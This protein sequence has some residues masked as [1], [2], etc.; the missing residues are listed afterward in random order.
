MR[1]QE[2][3]DDGTFV[4]SNKEQGGS[5]YFE[6][7]INPNNSGRPD[8]KINITNPT[9]KELLNYVQFMSMLSKVKDLHVYVLTVSED[10]FAGYINDMNYKTD[11]AS[12]DEEVDFLER[13]CVI[14]DYFGVEL[15]LNGGISNREYETVLH[16]SDLIRNDEV[17]GTWSEA[18]F[19]GIVSPHFREELVSMHGIGTVL[20]VLLQKIDSVC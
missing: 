20:Y 1:T 13:V 14:E 15:K 9:N 6:I 12:V 19:S 5:F 17:S 3:L 10:I 18:T 8:F 2:I 7:R 11:F 16:I 4:I